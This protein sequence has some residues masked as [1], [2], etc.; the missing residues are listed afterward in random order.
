MLGCLPA[1]LFI[2]MLIAKR[3]KQDP[4]HRSVDFA[5]SE[6]PT[7]R[8]EVAWCFPVC[9]ARAVQGAGGEV[10]VER[11]FLKRNRSAC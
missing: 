7:E 5:S 3:K 4:I 11:G 10:V 9:A 6:D 2:L 8:D 1:A